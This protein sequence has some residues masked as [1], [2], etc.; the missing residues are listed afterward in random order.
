LSQVFVMKLSAARAR[1]DDDL[2]VLWPPGFRTSE[3][4]ASALA[5]AFPH[6]PDD[7]HLVD[8]VRAIAEAAPDAS[9][10]TGG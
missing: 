8:Y 4:A 9:A 3:D 10:R 1:H 6:A 5:A 7:P 2:V